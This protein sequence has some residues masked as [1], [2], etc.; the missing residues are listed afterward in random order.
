MTDAPLPFGPQL[1]GRV[2]KSLNAFL[3][4]QLA[5]TGLSERQWVALR[6]TVLG[7]PAP[8]RA[9]LAARVAGVLRSGEAAAGECLAALEEAG[10]VGAGEDGTYG[11]YGATGAGSAFHD[12]VSAANARFTDAL[13]GDLPADELETAARV[14]RTVLARADQA[15]T[16]TT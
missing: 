11:G 2:E 10:L 5:G 15:L 3:E 14:L 13:W 16:A 9:R 7:G 12:R 6:L 8:D 1:V 4:R